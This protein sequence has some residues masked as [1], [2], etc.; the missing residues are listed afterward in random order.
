MHATLK[1]TAKKHKL[2]LSGEI[3]FAETN[4]LWDAVQQ[5]AQQPK[6]TQIDW[7]NLSRLHYAGVQ[8][9]FA[10]RKTLEEQ[11]CKLQFSEPNPSL[12]QQLHTFGVWDALIQA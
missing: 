3:G 2:T 5:I 1:T 11:G 12:Y 10:L 8:T 4:A 9:L 6:E 7:S